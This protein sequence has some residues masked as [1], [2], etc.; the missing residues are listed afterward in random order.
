MNYVYTAGYGNR[1]PDE[2]RKLL[3]DAGIT[4]VLDVRRTGRGRL[5]AYDTGDGM[6]NTMK[7]SGII[8]SHWPR[9]ANYSRS[10]LAYKRSLYS[11]DAKDQLDSL[12]GGWF[13][14][15]K[16]EERDCIICCEKYAYVNG[17]VNCHR[18]YIANALVRRIRK[19]SG[20]EW[21]VKHL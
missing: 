10:L 6:R 20:E 14:G 9:L 11:Y 19:Q 8:Y 5:R 12:A 16:P 1:A 17:K 18:V 13:W 3:V 4:H 15:R 2:F 7:E 21:E